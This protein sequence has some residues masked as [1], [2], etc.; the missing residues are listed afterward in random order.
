MKKTSKT[1]NTFGKALARTA[2][3]IGIISAGSACRWGF[4]Q[5]KVPEKMSTYIK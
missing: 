3:K 5:N 2:L 1:A 4:Y